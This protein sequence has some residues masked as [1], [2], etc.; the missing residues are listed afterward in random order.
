[1]LSSKTFI[2]NTNIA[3][4]AKKAQIEKDSI[5]QHYKRVNRVNG[6]KNLY[7]TDSDYKKKIKHQEVSDYGLAFG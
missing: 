5:Y 2:P 4:P 1:M 6:N 7:D 3:R